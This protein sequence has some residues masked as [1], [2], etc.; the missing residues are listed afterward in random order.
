MVTGNDLIRAISYWNL[1]KYE[2]DIDDFVGDEIEFTIFEIARQPEEEM[3]YCDIV[4]PIDDCENAYLKVW[5]FDYDYI[6][7]LSQIKKLDNYIS[8]LMNEMVEFF[9]AGKAWRGEDG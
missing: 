2:I 4:V 6:K 8:E 5:S 9:A 1:G 7:P 3:Y